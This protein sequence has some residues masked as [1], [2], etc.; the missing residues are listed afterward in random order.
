LKH[1]SGFASLRVGGLERVRRH[2]DLVMLGRLAQTLARTR[3]SQL[4]A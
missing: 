1:D 2:A 3:A 4:A